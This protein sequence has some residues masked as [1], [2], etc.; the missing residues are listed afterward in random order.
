MT[1]RKVFHASLLSL[2]ALF[3]LACGTPDTDLAAV[4]STH[5]ALSAI[6]SGC[7]SDTQCS[8]GL[9]WDTNDSYPTYN[10]S[11]EHGT[12]C[13]VECTP[14]AAGDTYC[15]NLAAQYNAPQP[16]SARCL[17]ARAVY[18][19]GEDG[20]FYICDLIQAGLGSYWSE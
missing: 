19:N 6:G 9:C 5:Q 8:T 18:D 3:P 4:D 2:I 13:T 1:M 20:S 10:P 14:G 7:S 15:R 11:W 17:F 16:N 12:L